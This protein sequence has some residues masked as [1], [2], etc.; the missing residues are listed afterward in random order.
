MKKV[1][2]AI[3]AVLVGM[4]AVTAGIMTYRKNVI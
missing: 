3:I 2:L 4:G 1:V